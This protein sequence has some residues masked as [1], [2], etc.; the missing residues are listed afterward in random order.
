MTLRG[1]CSEGTA[2]LEKQVTA[3]PPAVRERRTG[4]LA[5]LDDFPKGDILERC[6]HKRVSQIAAEIV[7]SHYGET[8]GNT[9]CAQKCIS[10]H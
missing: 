4:S 9:F 2:I 1:N 3:R 8:R 7:R 6:R 10:S 5:L